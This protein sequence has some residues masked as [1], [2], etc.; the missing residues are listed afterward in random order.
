[1]P[2]TLPIETI[3]KNLKNLN[4]WTLSND[5]KSIQKSFKFK[6]F[7]DTFAVMTKIATIAEQQ[8]HHPD[9]SN[10]YNKLHITLTSHDSGGITK[11]DITMAQQINQ[12]E[13][14]SKTQHPA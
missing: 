5:Q 6:N 1:M 11:R 8:N 12:F 3:K 14:Q 4:G 9:W 7:E 2:E 13:A 10:S